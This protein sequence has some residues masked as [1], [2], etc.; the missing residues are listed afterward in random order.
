MI[1]EELPPVPSLGE[2]VSCYWRFALP[3]SHKPNPTTH[4]VPPDGTVN[5]CW[6]PPGRG[7]VMG[8]RMNALR[9][10]VQAG[11][12]YFGVRLLP[13]VAGPLLGLDVKTLRNGIEPFEPS[14]FAATMRS[15]GLVGM[16]ALIMGWV[17]RS[18]CEPVDPV[19]AELTRRILALH[20]AVSVSAL[21]VGLRLSYR[22]VLRR[23]YEATAMTPKEFARLRRMREACLQAVRSA[24]PGWADVAVATG[25]SDQPHLVREF[26]D[27]YGWPPRL[28]QEYLRRIEHLSVVG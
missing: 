26:R 16:D 23:F 19:V 14:D 11:M 18:G 22:Q 25:F 20:G 12:S 3:T 9:V 17:Q 10:P 7:V 6:I 28:V 5:L 27:I 2:V 13:G 4:I 24:E 21:V 1:Y 8:P 15:S